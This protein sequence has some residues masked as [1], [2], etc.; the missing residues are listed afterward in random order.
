MRRLDVG[1]GGKEHWF[2][3][4]DPLC[5]KLDC[6][7]Y[8]GVLRWDCPDRMPLNSKTIDDCYVGQLL[9]ECSVSD[10]L[11]LASEL[12]RVMKRKSLIRVHCYSGVPGFREFFYKMGVLGWDVESSDLVNKTDEV[13]TFMVRLRRTHG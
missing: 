4:E 10:H 7:T 12:D 3:P 6:D 9:I 8:E 5:I 2:W 13:E 1:S 11:M